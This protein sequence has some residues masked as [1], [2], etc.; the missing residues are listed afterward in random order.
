MFSLVFSGFFFPEVFSLPRAG[1]ATT[2]S[3]VRAAAHCDRRRAIAH[4]PP[5]PSVLMSTPWKPTPHRGDDG[6][7]DAADAATARGRACGLEAILRGR[8]LRGDSARQRGASASAARGAAGRATPLREHLYRFGA[9][10]AD[11]D[12][13]AK[14]TLGGKG[15]VRAR[16]RPPLPA[17]FFYFSSQTTRTRVHT[18]RPPSPFV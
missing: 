10:A 14:E 7:D 16:V 15:A 3:S 11:G 9:G 17:V 1:E 12:A 13:T 5:H 4:P 18:R 6:D 8:R 2:P